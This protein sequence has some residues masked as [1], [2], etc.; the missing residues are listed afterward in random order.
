MTEIDNLLASSL[1]ELEQINHVNALEA[2][3]VQYLGRKGAITEILRGLGA[4]SIEER[5]AVGASANQ[6]KASLE[7]RY[8]EKRAA[9]LAEAEAAKATASLLDISLPGYPPPQGHRHPVT[10]ALEDLQRIFL[11]MG[12]QTADGPEVEWDYYNFEA[13]N[14]PAEHPARDN[15]STFWVDTNDRA[16]G[17]AAH[18]YHVG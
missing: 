11:S 16:S 8:D 13:L 4:I 3:R 2:W 6:A 15:M 1:Q 14:I 12:F 5:R 17:S 9:L 7:A 18:P 10:Q